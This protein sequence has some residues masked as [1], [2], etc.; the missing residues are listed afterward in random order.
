MVR[1]GM[2]K[3]KRTICWFLLA[4]VVLVGGQA[5][6]AWINGTAR[7]TYHVN[8]FR[9]RGPVGLDR[10]TVLWRGQ[11][12][13]VGRDQPTFIVGP[14]T[15]LGIE[16][17]L[18]QAHETSTVGD[19]PALLYRT[20]TIAPGAGPTRRGSAMDHDIS[21]YIPSLDVGISVYFR[22]HNERS[23]RPYD[24]IEALRCR[25]WAS[26]VMS[27]IEWDPQE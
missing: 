7:A 11:G 10:E 18:K 25:N 15:E 14:L 24:H 27:S 1:I 8:G 13:A 17:L 20:K 3:H 21:I 16:Y 5:T 22:V 12:G 26:A 9:F 4:V 2:S 23:S 6:Y 19:L